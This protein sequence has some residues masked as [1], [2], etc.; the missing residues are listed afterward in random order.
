M[1]TEHPVFVAYDHEPLGATLTVPDGDAEAL[2]LLL[3]GT[4]APRSHRFQLWTRTARALAERGLASIRVDYRGIGDSAGRVLQPV[5]GDQ[6]TDQAIAAARFG[7][8]ASGVS[9]LAVIG[10]C[11]GGVVGLGVTA[12]MEETETAVL[13]L[14]RLVYMRGVS[15]AAVEARKSRLG[16]VVRRNALLRRVAHKTIKGGGRRDIPSPPVA[17][18]FEP[19]TQN[20]RLMFIYSEHDRDPYVAKSRRLL[21]QL[22]AK[23]PADRRSK[24]ESS[25]IDEGPLSGFE[26]LA[27][28]ESVI[29]AAV[30]WTVRSLGI[31]RD[32]SPQVGDAVGVRA[33]R[34]R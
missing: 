21:E 28:Q 31:D 17:Q 23:L 19:A 11:S 15:R 2:V 8:Q 14:P 5:L 4:G 18:F 32:P 6:R 1:T 29:A 13:I 34:N 25:L 26:S 30:D 9:R 3:A 22:T 7:M 10:N 33:R 27:V 16:A 24:V 12:Q 20:A